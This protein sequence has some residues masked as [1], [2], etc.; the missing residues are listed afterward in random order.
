MNK[1]DI[2]FTPFP[3]LSR[4]NREIVV[5]EKI[6]GTNAGIYITE[7][8]T[9]HASSRNRW[10]TPEDDN[11]GFA[12]WVDSNKEIL[13][14]LGPG[15]HFGEWWGNGIQRNYGLKEK[16]FSL[17]NTGRWEWV[18]HVTPEQNPLAGV[19]GVVPVLY[20]GLFSQAHINSVLDRLVSNG[21]IA[22]SGWTKPEGVVVFHSASNVSYKITLDGDGHK[23]ANK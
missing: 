7:E 23:G 21:S 16:R 5:T 10:I 17:F 22:V 4:L 8:G 20:Q 19:V 11:S 2:E 18:N 14:I 6:D 12:R 1:P 15:Q 9:I 13:S 3:K